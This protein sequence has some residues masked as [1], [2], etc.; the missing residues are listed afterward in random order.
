M[1]HFCHTFPLS[2]KLPGIAQGT[3]VASRG[4]ESP[5]INA[6]KNTS[7]KPVF[8]CKYINILV[9]L[10]FSFQFCN[11]ESFHLRFGLFHAFREWVWIDTLS[12]DLIVS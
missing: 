8:V 10:V 9:S 1:S 2:S 11:S 12:Q 7:A 4:P 3:T 6:E 5:Q